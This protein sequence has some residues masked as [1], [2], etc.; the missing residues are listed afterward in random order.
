MNMSRGTV[1]TTYRQL[2]KDFNK[3]LNILKIS[4]KRLGKPG[5]AAPQPDA[6]RATRYSCLLSVHA[7]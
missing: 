7:R 2:K 4:S 5:G 3:L 6:W 1:S